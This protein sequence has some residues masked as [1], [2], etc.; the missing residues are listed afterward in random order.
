[1]RHTLSFPDLLDESSRG[2]QIV[3]AGDVECCSE[4]VQV[5]VHSGP[6]GSRLRDST[7]ILDTLVYVYAQRHP[8]ESII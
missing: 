3:V 5:V 8:L 2:F 4:G 6:Y 7:S 1:M